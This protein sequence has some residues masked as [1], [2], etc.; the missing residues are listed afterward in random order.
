MLVRIVGNLVSNA[1]KYT[2]HGGVLVAARQ[3]GQR[4]RIDIVDTGMGI[5]A[6]HQQRIFDEFYQIAA[7]GRS[8]ERGMGLGLATVQRL[9]DLLGAEVR[10]TSVVGRG[11]WV[12]VYL[13]LFQTDSDPVQKA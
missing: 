7:A 3:R 11:T 6:E 2:K 9:T 13:P 12:Q 5:H 10:L 4:V 8:A 1:L